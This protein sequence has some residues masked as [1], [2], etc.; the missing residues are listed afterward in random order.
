M[1]VTSFAR[2]VGLIFGVG[3]WCSACGGSAKDAPLTIGPS[4]VCEAGSARCDGSAIKRCN[5]SGSSESIESTCVHGQCALSDAGVPTC[6]SS[7]A[8]PSTSPPVTTPTCAAGAAAC[9]GSRAT[10]CNDDGSGF[11]S[12]GADC[13]A[14]K[15]ICFQGTCRPTLCVAGTRSCQNGDI[16]VCAAD[17]SGLSLSQA[18]PSGQVC[19]DTS[20][21]C[22]A[23]TCHPGEVSCKGSSVVT[24]NSL[25]NGWL[26]D[27]QDCS[28]DGRVCL[29]GICRKPTC[30]ASTTFCADGNLYRCD[31]SG[32]SSSLA[33]TCQPGVEHCEVTPA[34]LYA[35]CV[36]NE[37]TPSKPTCDGDVVKTC[38][39]DGS[40]P[41]AGTACDAD[42]YC[43][44]GQCK[45][46][47]CAP[48]YQTYCKGT[49]VYYCD[50]D[51]PT[52]YNDCGSDAQCLDLEPD[53]LPSDSGSNSELVSCFPLPCQP[54]ESACV[55]NKLGV[56]GPDGTTLS[57]VTLDC[58]TNGQ[59]CTTDG[60]CL[61]SVTDAF[62]GANTA[63][64]S[65]NP[66]V[67]LGNLIEIRSSRLLTELQ[68]WL[69]FNS[70]QTLHWVVYEQVGPS[71]IARADV[72][73]NE[74]SS[75]GYVSSGPLS[76]DYELEAGKRYALGVFITELS[77]LS[78]YNMP[79]VN[80]SFARVI[81]NVYVYNDVTT[82]DLSNG[83]STGYAMQMKT[84]TQAP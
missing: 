77:V 79:F 41:E 26:P 58:T 17:G 12:A 66:N 57:S 53:A 60:A 83:F 82:F 21:T 50:H 78:N 33:Q 44:D 1:V 19:D 49:N 39:P 15:Q 11:V 34:G 59:V 75:T 6:A 36:L 40:L 37:C 61:A 76:F 30:P 35:F 64:N 5:A 69:V 4:A 72:K 28:A 3:L 55:Q 25:G 29:A 8:P 20:V 54:G 52:L 22:V 63:L 46:R 47:G 70:A 24:C 7:T 38:N 71:M 67:Y 10:R 45:P 23:N 68:T 62:G 18:C 31:S 13:A 84:V 51:G 43:Q 32:A 80:P 16:F 74:T 81:G 14:S 42:S 27:T 9:D 2:W 48:L 56:C 73:T 65:Y